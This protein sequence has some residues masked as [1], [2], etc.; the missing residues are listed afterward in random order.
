[1]GRGDCLTQRISK[2][3]LVPQV[4]T[5][6]TAMVGPIIDMQGSECT[7]FDII[8]GALTDTNAIFA[9]TMEFGDAPNLAGAESPAA[10]DLVGTLAGAG[11]TFA[12]DSATRSFGYIGKRRYARMTITPTGNDS[13]NIPLAALAT[14]SRR[15]LVSFDQSN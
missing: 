1:M 10:D 9:V 14:L 3:A 6:N 4:G 8:T 12:A 5:D 2:V 7:T 13:G 11:F 15:R